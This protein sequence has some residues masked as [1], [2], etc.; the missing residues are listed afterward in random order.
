MSE[1]WICSAVEIQFQDLILKSNWTKSTKGAE[2]WNNFYNRWPRTVVAY[3]LFEESCGGMYKAKSSKNL[4]FLFRYT[5]LWRSLAS[6]CHGVYPTKTSV[7]RR[8][9]TTED[10]EGA[11]SSE[12]TPFLEVISPL[13]SKDLSTHTDI[14]ETAGSLVVFWNGSLCGKVR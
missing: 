3:L 6:V 4:P 10:S 7:Q 13:R 8:S 9:G 1:F 14:I 11:W 2:F 12:L 5:N